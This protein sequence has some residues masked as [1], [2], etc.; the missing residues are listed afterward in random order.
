MLLQAKGDK[1]AAPKLMRK[2]LKK[3]GFVPELMITDDPRSNGASARV[4][5]AAT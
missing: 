2:P 3:Y 5:R 4:L 1:H